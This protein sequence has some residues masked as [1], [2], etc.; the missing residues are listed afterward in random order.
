VTEESIVNLNSG[1]TWF[2]KQ[3]S[4]E[5]ENEDNFQSQ[6]MMLGF[7]SSPQFI[8]VDPLEKNYGQTGRDSFMSNDSDN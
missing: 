5:N 1:A 8:N 4:I 7:N 2:Y 3:S 6:G